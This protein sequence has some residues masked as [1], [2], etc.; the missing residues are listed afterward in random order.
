MCERFSYLSLCGAM[1]LFVAPNGHA[2]P[3]ERR[4]LLGP[5]RKIS[6]RS[7]YFAPTEAALLFGCLHWRL[8]L[9]DPA[10]AGT[11]EYVQDHLFVGNEG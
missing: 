7:E 6:A 3:I 4:P 10:A 9:D 8:S 11:D 2:D 1:S 5:K